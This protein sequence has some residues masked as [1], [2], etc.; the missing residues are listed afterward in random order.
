MSL[1]LEF[2]LHPKRFFGELGW[3]GESVIMIVHAW[4]HGGQ[5]FR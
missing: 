2:S 5:H 1:N 3:L 4:G